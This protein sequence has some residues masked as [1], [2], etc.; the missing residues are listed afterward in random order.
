MPASGP[1]AA[2][3]PSSSPPGP[4]QRSTKT[5]GSARCVFEG[6][7][8]TSNVGPFGDGQGGPAGQATNVVTDYVKVHGESRSHDVKFIGA[9]TSAY[10]RAF[11]DAAG[12]V[13]NDEGKVAKIKFTSFRNYFPYRLK[14][15]SPVV[16]QAQAVAKPL[17]FEP[18][19]STSN[20]GLDANWLVRLGIP[21]I[22]FGAGQNDVHT[23]GEFVHLPDFL[24]GC[25]YALALACAE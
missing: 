11:Q 7:E 4:W 16:Q 13:K 1:S 6:K 25:S 20:G 5:A 21:A 14:D 2:S 8:G 19:L 3:R 12:A 22:T 24:G 18:V 9:I 15:K 17:G 10:R 23:T